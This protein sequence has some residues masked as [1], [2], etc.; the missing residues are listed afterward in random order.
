MEAKK[1]VSEEAQQDTHNM[2]S[3]VSAFT[4]FGEVTVLVPGSNCLYRVKHG[5]NLYTAIKQVGRRE[6]VALQVCPPHP[7]VLRLLK[8]HSI[9]GL[10]VAETLWYSR[11]LQ[12]L[13]FST[14]SKYYQYY[15]HHNN[16]T[17]T[18]QRHSSLP[19]P[20]IL[21]LPPYTNYTL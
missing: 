12:D 8:S 18:Q 14:S 6:L 1:Q 2:P 10:A 11:D 19:S 9:N 7:C 17:L 4:T 3:W 21:P 5:E 13:L 16:L 20:Q 15:Y